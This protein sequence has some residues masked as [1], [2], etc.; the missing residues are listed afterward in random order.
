M[1]YLDAVLAALAAL[2]N[3]PIREKRIQSQLQPA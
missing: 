1:W 2:F 3:L